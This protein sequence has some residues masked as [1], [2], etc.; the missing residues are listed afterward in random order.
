[1]TF[2]KTFRK[3]AY[4]LRTFGSYGKKETGASR[5]FAFIEFTN[6]EDAQS[7]MEVKQG[8]LMFKDQYR[9]TMQ[10][11]L[12]R[13]GRLDPTKSHRDWFCGQC[14]VQNFRRR[15][16]CF[17]CGSP[18][19]EYDVMQEGNEEVSVHPTT[20]LLLRGL[21]ALTTEESVSKSLSALCTLSIKSIQIARD[22]LTNMSRGFA[23]VEMSNLPDA[24]L[25]H[26]QLLG[27][28][29]LIDD[30][31]VA[32]SYYKNPIQFHG[33]SYDHA[34]PL[35]NSNNGIH[36]TPSGGSGGSLTHNS[37]SQVANLALAAAQ[38]SNK[39]E[40]LKEKN[41]GGGASKKNYSPEEIDKMANYS[42]SMYAKNAK[43]EAHYY[44]YYKNLYN[45]GGDTSAASIALREEN[46][47]K[48]NSDL[49]TVTVGGVEYKKYPSPDV[50]SY[51]YDETSGYYYDPISG[52]YYDAN[53]TYY[54][55]SNTSQYHYWASEH[56]TFLPVSPEALS[57]EASTAKKKE[58]TNPKDKVKT[59][60][61]IA[62]DMERWAKSM[63]QRKEAERE[64]A[65]AAA[66]SAKAPPTPKA[67]STSLSKVPEAAAKL[68]DVAFSAMIRNKADSPPPPNR[69]QSGLPGLANYGSEEDSGEDNGRLDEDAEEEQHTNWSTLACL[70]CKR[71]FTSK[72]KLSKHN[73]MSDLHKQNLAEWRNRQGMIMSSSPPASSSLGISSSS[74]PQYRD[75]AKERRDKFGSLDE[76]PRPNHLKE[77]Y[78]KV[79]EQADT[80]GSVEKTKT[81]GLDNIGNRMLQKMGWKEGL[82]LGK[83]NQGRTSIIEVGQRNV[84]AGLGSSSS[85]IKMDPSDSYKDCVKKTLYQ[86]YHDL[87]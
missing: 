9:A 68:S 86:R 16:L 71:Q 22:S 54:F 84:Q 31:L 75:R 87:N 14:G 80:P 49:G 15:D 57:E 67:P 52:L 19:T 26:N 73:Q 10:Y 33:P 20:C 17:K 8:V 61:K 35:P 3:Q 18:K 59:A 53:S 29:P 5:G 36:G 23:Y 1:M 69:R 82:G 72:E 45:N 51:Q 44:E 46:N 56:M 78:L 58:A 28:P 77:K 24:I 32:V 39:N 55:N 66:T 63:N 70:L 76:E 47:S 81:V 38:W 25:L 27:S 2:D 83:S 34:P 62:K 48:K 85:R 37:N 40:D 21:D 64:K 65:A 79:L 6:V 30:K 4:P 42:A 60:K 41:P 7:W 43:E 13:E 11:S 12:P 74:V 50:S